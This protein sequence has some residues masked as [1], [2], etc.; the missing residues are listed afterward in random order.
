MSKDMDRLYR[1]ID[2]KFEQMSEEELLEY[3]IN[4]ELKMKKIGRKR[5]DSAKKSGYLHGYGARKDDE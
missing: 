1:N 3:E 2:K 4:E 5:Y